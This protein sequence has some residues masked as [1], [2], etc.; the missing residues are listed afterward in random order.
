MFVPKRSLSWLKT[1]HI[2]VY[3]DIVSTGL[4][5]VV[6]ESIPKIYYMLDNDIA[7]IP[8]CGVC[9][10]SPVI[11]YRG[12]L[13]DVCSNKCSIK[14]VSVQEKT[15]NTCIEKYG[16]RFNHVNPEEYGMGE[17]YL[18][19]CYKNLEDIHNEQLV[20]SILENHGWVGIAEHFGTNKNSHTSTYNL[21]RKYGYDPL[22]FSSGSS[23]S[24]EKEVFEYIRSL[25]FSPVR[26]KNIIPPY[27]LDVYVEEKKLAIEFNGIFWHS[28]NTKETDFESKKRHIRKTDLCE[29]QGIHLL[30]IFEHEWDDPIK[31]SI[32]K[33]VIR[34][35]LGLSKK[36]Y[37]RKCIIKE[38]SYKE[39]EEFIN[40]NHL[41]GNCVSSDRLGL[42]YN[43]EL[44]M[45][46]TFGKSRYSS[47][48]KQELLRMCSKCGYVIVG[49]ASK[50]LKDKHFI[51]YANRRWSFGNVYSKIGMKLI[52]NSEPCYWYTKGNDV[53]HRSSFMK[54]KLVNKLDAF[55]P[56]LTESE[57]MYNNGYRRF[58][59]CGNLIYEKSIL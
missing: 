21:L 2:E 41:Q 26:T 52:G 39:S 42:F 51:S 49:G 1:N 4:I 58:W 27:E 32:W 34:N 31:Q 56:S 35:K 20:Y 3:D 5:E 47:K 16:S 14:S 50:L 55:D 40:N 22:K 54:H 43:D 13:L 28:S 30:H 25:G 57:N 29:K 53:Y 24:K 10:S 8:M 59:D 19:K 37:A 18:H 23:S 7:S 38:I 46:A 48:T 36:I 33:S 17:H 45:V 6:G 12:K 9:G 11:F 15:K 44:V